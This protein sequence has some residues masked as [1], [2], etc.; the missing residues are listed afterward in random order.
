MMASDPGKRFAT[1]EALIRELMF[2]AENLGLTGVSSEGMVWMSAGAIT[3]RNWEKH[4]GWMAT[5]ALLVVLAVVLRFQPVDRGEVL[6]GGER[7]AMG[8]SG[9]DRAAGA[10]QSPATTDPR[11]LPPLRDQ[12]AATGAEAGGEARNPG[13]GDGKSTGGVVSVPAGGS[14]TAE[15]PGPDPPPS[16]PVAEPATPKTVASISS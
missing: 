10:S 6:S 13:D 1:P 3:G 4:I 16:D 11:Q 8:D 7:L 9:G 2:V 15:P 14:V 5:V 12:M